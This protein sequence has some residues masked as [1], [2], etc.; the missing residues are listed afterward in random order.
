MPKRGEH[1]DDIAAVSR[2]A[3]RSFFSAIKLLPREFDAAAVE[4]GEGGGSSIG[5]S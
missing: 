2:T 1:E 4:W 5:G 3:A